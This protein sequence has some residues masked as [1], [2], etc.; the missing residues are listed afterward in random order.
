MCQG[1]GVGSS[2]VTVLGKAA[3]SSRQTGGEWAGHPADEAEASSIDL[4]PRV[5]SNT[6][7]TKRKQTQAHSEF[8][9]VYRLHFASDDLL[10][11][12]F[13]VSLLSLS[14]LA[15]CWLCVLRPGGSLCG[16]YRENDNVLKTLHK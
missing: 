7:Q 6:P 4:I 3:R 12:V 11:C 13:C 2:P 14:L 9:A 5:C 8:K 16:R 1:V 10:L 15:L